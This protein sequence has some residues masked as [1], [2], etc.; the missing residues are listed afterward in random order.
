[1]DTKR[2]NAAR[3]SFP[4]DS[5]GRLDANADGFS[6]Q[7]ADLQRAWAVAIGEAPARLQAASTR[8]SL[9]ILERPVTPE[10][11]AASSK[12]IARLTGALRSG[13]FFGAARQASEHER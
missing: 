1:M 10:P 11:I 12:R 6:A 9:V 8:L 13:Q 4:R 7:V 3:T 2:V 5:G